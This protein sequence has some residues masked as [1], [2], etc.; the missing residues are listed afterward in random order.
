MGQTN[1]CRKVADRNPRPSGQKR[2][3]RGLMFP[4]VCKIGSGIRG[5]RTVSGRAPAVCSRCDGI[6]WRGRI[7]RVSSLVNVRGTRLWLLPGR[8]CCDKPMAVVVERNYAANHGDALPIYPV[9]SSKHKKGEVANSR[10]NQASPGAGSGTVTGVAARCGAVITRMT[11]VRMTAAAKIVRTVM[12]SPAMSHP[13]NSATTG[14][15]NA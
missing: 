14:F 15:T 3:W 11:A 12:V 1:G 10:N 8:R 6:L 4:S 5:S 7:R 9:R 13:R 2:R